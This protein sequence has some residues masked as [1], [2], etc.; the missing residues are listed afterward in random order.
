MLYTV[1]T[2]LADGKSWQGQLQKALFSTLGETRDD[3]TATTAQK[4]KFKSDI[5]VPS[6]GR[7]GRE[8]AYPIRRA[9]TRAAVGLE[10]ARAVSGRWW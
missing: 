10:A 2:T 7:W 5:T 3:P 6:G 8:G 9:L 1:P 4:H